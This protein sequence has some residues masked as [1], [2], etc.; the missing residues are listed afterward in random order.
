M[1]I[2]NARLF[3][4]CFKSFAYAEST[5]WNKSYIGKLRG[6][7]LQLIV[8]SLDQW[9]IL[10]LSYSVHTLPF[11]DIIHYKNVSVLKGI[12]LRKM[13]EQTAGTNVR[14]PSQ[15]RVR[16]EIELTVFFLLGGKRYCDSKV[17]YPRAQYSDSGQDLI[18][19]LQIRKTH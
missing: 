8:Y 7:S 17:T 18:Q 3:K 9:A 19:D 16:W 15:G 13:T 6:C 11:L 12:K 1:W 14:C 10:L 4:V 2:I 5:K